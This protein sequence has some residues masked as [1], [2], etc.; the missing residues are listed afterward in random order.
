MSPE[1]Q[2]Y[3]QFKGIVKKKTLAE[4][5]KE[6]AA[7]IKCPWCFNKFDKPTGHPTICKACACGWSKERLAKEGLKRYGT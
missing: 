3:Q 4:N 6:I 2:L 7:G 5:K 1:D